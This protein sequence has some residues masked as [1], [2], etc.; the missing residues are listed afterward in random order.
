MQ[1]QPSFKVCLI[2][3]SQSGKS[4]FLRQL[5]GE[6]TVEGKEIKGYVPTEGCA[7]KDMT[8]NTNHGSYK[9]MFWDIGAHRSHTGLGASYYFG[10]HAALAFYSQEEDCK[11]TNAIVKDYKRVVES[12][13]I[14]NVWASNETVPRGFPKL[15]EYRQTLTVDKTDQDCLIKPIVNLLRNL[16][17]KDDLVVV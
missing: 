11:K 17:G 13:T 15:M 6:K 7:F 3:A 1:K 4:K 9:I 14:V 8:F 2:G 10:S 12:S 5:L 16:T